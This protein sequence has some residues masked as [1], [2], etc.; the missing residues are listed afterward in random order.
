MD[1]QTSPQRLSRRDFHRLNLL[2]GCGALAT[3]TG[4]G[5]LLYPER[6]GQ[7]RTG[8]VDWGVVGMD[9][10]GLLFFFVPGVIAF[11]VDIYNGTL[12]HTARYSPAEGETKFS[13]VDLH[14]RN[15]KHGEIAAAISKATGHRITLEEGTFV[16]KP[17]KSLEEFPLVEQELIAQLDKGELVYRCQSPE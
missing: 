4:C 1:V 11:A 9:A 13:K 16:T 2:A 5:T 3:S 6:I 7:P 17:L 10:I 14:R 15:P 12:F 8:P